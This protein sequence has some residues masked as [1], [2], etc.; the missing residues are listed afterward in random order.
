MS[1]T[2]RFA[3]GGLLVLALG[4]LA[5]YVLGQLQPYEKTLKLGPAPE[6]DADPYLAAEYF[7]RERQIAVSRADGL[8]V[9]RQLPAPGQTLM[10]LSSREDMTPRQARQ[11]LEWTAKGG[12][13]V[14]VAESLW[15]EEQGKSDDLLLDSLGI[16]Q[17]LTE[18]L[19]EAADGDEDSSTSEADE[20][21]DADAD[22]ATDSDAAEPAEA[23]GDNEDE[24]GEAVAAQVEAED[25]DRYPELTKLY[26]ENEQ[27]PAYVDFDTDF[28]LY[29]AKNRAHAWAN[30]G[31][32]THML[33]LY[34]GD[35]LVTV[36]TDAWLW[37]NDSIDAYDNAWLLWYLSQDSSVTLLYSKVR[38]SLLSQLFE[39]YPAALTAL[40]LLIVLLLW[41][42]GLRHGPLQSP[43][44]HARRQ[45]EEHLRGSADFLLRRTSQQHLLHSLQ[46]DI[47]RRARH[48]HPGFE[49]LAVADQWQVLGRLTRIPTSA[50]S[51]AMRPAPAHKLSAADFTRQ[52]ANLQT[53]RN[54]L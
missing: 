45:L 18:D 51:Q 22:S 49:R 26:L 3:L 33:Q 30:S 35:G 2:G 43:P 7:L 47:Q 39:H 8:A 53:L 5:I 37:Q 40:A 34:H 23:A 25:D 46:R 42:A 15:D 12:H 44:S 54:A 11:V 10:L 1:R 6:V 24:L 29:D 48:R 17:H 9:L 21:A 28:H 31:A 52:V 14:F 36:L 20:Q 41:H 19:D 27:A 38:D 4:L 50:I 13:L 32:A 16:Q